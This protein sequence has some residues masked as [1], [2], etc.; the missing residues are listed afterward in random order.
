MITENLCCDKMCTSQQKSVA[1]TFWNMVS[2]SGSNWSRR[3]VGGTTDG[4]WDSLCLLYTLSLSFQHAFSLS[5]ISINI[6]KVKSKKNEWD[7]ERWQKKFR[8]INRVSRKKKQGRVTLG[9]END[10]NGCWGRGIDGERVEI[11]RGLEKEKGAVLMLAEGRLASDVL[12]D[13]RGKNWI[14]ADNFSLA[15]ESKMEIYWYLPISPK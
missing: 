10:E 6:S 13:K 8:N 11:R 5:L 14:F 1:K 2:L 7:E 12:R 4:F 3:I 15:G 9:A